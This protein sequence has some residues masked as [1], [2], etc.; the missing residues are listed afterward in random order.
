MKQL[1]KRKR[2]INRV[3]LAKEALTACLTESGFVAGA[4]HF[5]DLWARDSLFATFGAN[6]VGLAEASKR[7]IETF[8]LH[9]RADGLIPYLILRSHHNLGKY[10]GR[11]VYF[12]TPKAQFRS[13]LSYGTVPDGGI[14]TIIAAKKYAESSRDRAFLKKNYEQLRKALRWYGKKFDMGLIR[15]WF[16]CEWADAILKI[17]KTL[18]TNVL[19]FRATGDMVWIAK[20]LKKERDAKKYMR[21][22][23]HLGE[24]IH[25]E[26]WNG[27]HFADWKDWKR[28]DYFAAH[29]NMM[30]IV[31]GLA[32]PK[33][34]DV[35]LTKAKTQLWNGWTLRNT[36][37]SYPWWRVPLLHHLV[38]L[39]DYHN[40]MV[41]LQ[42]GLMYT[43]ALH[44]AG[45]TKRAKEVLQSIGQKIQQHHGVYEVY[46]IHG[47]PTKRL[48]YT[49][50]HPFAWSAGLFLWAHSLINIP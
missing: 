30:A 1:S 2:N 14:L 19:Y 50:E 11:H 37:P 36:V 39:P 18:Y 43:V 42:P 28:Q 13:H 24:C 45:K 35:I 20:E 38:G 31:F 4:H 16:L 6:A 22:H 47:K 34:R 27:S 25:K 8:L 3:F 10:F 41:W 40:G 48:F 15:E 5:V 23:K 33:E 49:S 46:E 29:P 17:G 21:W 44:I 9:Q 32:T 12:K 7:T 26:F